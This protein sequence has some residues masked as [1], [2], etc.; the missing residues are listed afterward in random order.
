MMP[1]METLKR[2]LP[3]A[4][5]FVVAIAM[6]GWGRIPQPPH[7]HAF[8]DGRVLWGVAHGADV[9]SNAGFALVGLWGLARL[10][11]WHRSPHLEG[12]RAGAWLFASAL[13][14]TAFGSAYYHLA[15]D[16]ARL[17]W[18]RLPIAL[19]CAGLLAAAYA[20]TH[21]NVSS[22][23]LA[24]ALAVLGAGSVFWW[25]FTEARGVGDLRLYLLL[26]GAPLV[27]VPLWQWIAGSPLRERLAFAGAILLYV[28]AK[29]AEVNDRAFF[30]A[31]GAVSGH[32]LK[33][34][35]AAGAGAVLLGWLLGPRRA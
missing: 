32:T 6:V 29:A 18:D 8:A 35:L 22:A 19:A 26:Q 9:L 4:I 21:D 30:E 33:H 5:L 13:L 28:L 2:S 25:S 17:V 1:R 23:P 16:N 20:R 27:L 3:M 24:L 34:G 10:A 14:L 7:Y 15:P 12:L 31:L 11:R